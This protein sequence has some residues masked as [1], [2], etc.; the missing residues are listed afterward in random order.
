MEITCDGQLLFFDVCHTDIPIVPESMDQITSFRIQDISALPPARPLSLLTTLRH[1]SKKRFEVL[2]CRLSVW[3]EDIEELST[4]R[5]KRGERERENPRKRRSMV[6]GR[7]RLFRIK[8]RERR[9]GE[10]GGGGRGRREKEEKEKRKEAIEFEVPEFAEEADAVIRRH[11]DSYKASLRRQMEEVKKRWKMS[12]V[13]YDPECD[14]HERMLLSLWD[15]ASPH[16]PL[17][18]RV[19]SQWSYLGFQGKDPATDFRG[20]GV[21]ALQC[22][23]FFAETYSADVHSILRSH[24]PYP[25]ATFGINLVQFMFKL[26]LIDDL[27]MMR[28][29]STDI[30]LSKSPFL[31]FLAS[32]DTTDAFDHAFCQLFLLFDSLWVRLNA[33]YMDFPR[34]LETLKVEVDRILSRYPHSLRQFSA[35]INQS[36]ISILSGEKRVSIDCSSGRS[37]DYDDFSLMIER[38]E[39]EEEG[40]GREWGEE[41]AEGREERKEEGEGVE[42]RVGEVREREIGIEIEEVERREEG[43]GKGEGNGERLC[44][45]EKQ[46][47]DE[48]CVEKEEKENGCGDKV[49]K[50]NREV[51]EENKES[52][53]LSGEEK[54]KR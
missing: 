31:D 5:R 41:D 15:A 18:S 1:T 21:L 37:H 38:E 26:L 39:E 54:E 34:V 40:V 28:T 45:D 25:F 35:W 12:K 6:V 17:K 24:R 11:V 3:V 46:K 50:S 42:K 30:R 32:A 33:G 14:A 7:R 4:G 13:S 51:E 36:V 27:D 19:S 2:T 8:W 23:L 48:L 16:T 43:E 10:G 47:K 49:E 20:M 9:G 44:V 52:N 53:S 22:L 29:T